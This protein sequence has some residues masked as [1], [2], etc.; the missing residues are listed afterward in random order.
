MNNHSEYERVDD[1]GKQEHLQ[2]R[3]S[4]YWNWILSLQVVNHG[5]EIA[6]KG[7]ES[8]LSACKCKTEVFYVFFKMFS[9]LFFRAVILQELFSLV[10][11]ASDLLR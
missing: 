1:N 9:P 5:F 7:H 4:G 3:S 10:C 2:S 11:K 6:V 8:F